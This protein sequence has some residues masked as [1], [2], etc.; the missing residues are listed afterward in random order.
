MLVSM[1]AL[2]NIIGAD[3]KAQSLQSVIDNLNFALDNMS[4]T[5]RTG[6]TYHCTDRTGDSFPSMGDPTL[7]QNCQYYGSS[8]IAL[9]SSRGST[10]NPNDQVIYYFNPA[11]VGFVGG[12][13][14]RSEDGGATF[15]PI[16]APDIEIENARF[17]VQGA[18]SLFGS[19]PG[20]TASD[21]ETQ[22]RVVVVLTARI[23]VPGGTPTV[24]RLQTTLTQR[25]YDA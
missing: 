13:I 7:P 11:C 23:Q 17:Y 20:C 15:L 14:E 25:V 19:E 3:R 12:C 2:M 24:L 8:Y 22:P 18:C 6:M 21:R 5:I 10:S 4:R 1:G 16:T 9:E